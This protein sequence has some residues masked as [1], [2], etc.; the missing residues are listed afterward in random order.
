[1]ARNWARIA[2][3]SCLSISPSTPSPELQSGEPRLGKPFLSYDMQP[4]SQVW[5]KGYIHNLQTRSPAATC[6][7]VASVR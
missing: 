4:L 3:I 6:I 1:M 2:V 5:G 7:G